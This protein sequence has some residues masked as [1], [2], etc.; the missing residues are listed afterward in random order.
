[1]IKYLALGDSYTI[2]TGASS[3]ARSWPA[4]V[5]ARLA[6]QSGGQVELTNPAINGFT[7][8]DLIEDELP[9][10]GRLEPDLITILIG[11]NDLVRERTPE[12]YRTSLVRIYDAVAKEKAA[13]GRVFAVSIPNWSMVPAARQYGDPEQIRHLTDAFNDVAR[14]EATARGFGWIDITAASISGLGSPGWISADGLHPGDRQYAAWAEVIW[15]TVRA[16]SGG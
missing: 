15:Y 1:M 9:Q 7:T 13:H 11:V 3:P 12:A 4:I 14:E 8:Q 6:E 16:G 5:A 2:G 10:V